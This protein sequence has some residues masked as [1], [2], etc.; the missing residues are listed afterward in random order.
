VLV[1]IA[2]ILSLLL[3]ILGFHPTPNG[4]VSEP[5]SQWAPHSK[6]Q[7][8]P[9]I[10]QQSSSRSLQTPEKQWPVFT[11]LETLI[12]KSKPLVS[13]RAP[14]VYEHLNVFRVAELAD[15]RAPPQLL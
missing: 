11:L 2:A 14:D 15:S 4:S 3:F 9:L 13:I 5:L 7:A 8:L 10:E 6:L 1:R 12:L